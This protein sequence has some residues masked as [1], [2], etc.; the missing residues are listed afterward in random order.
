MDLTTSDSLALHG[1]SSPPD[2]AARSA[3]APPGYAGSRSD[4]ERLGA[5]SS[6]R[7][8]KHGWWVYV[9]RIARRIWRHPANRSR[10]L[11]ALGRSLAWQVRKR[12]TD[13]PMEIGIGG[14]LKILCF[15]D[16]SV[17]SSLIYASGWPEIDEMQFVQ[18]YLRPGDGFVDGG[19]NIGIYTL[20]AASKVGPS[21]WIDA[22]EPSPTALQRLRQNISHNGLSQVRTHAAALGDVAGTARLLV[23]WDVS[24]RL[25]GSEDNQREDEQAVPVP[26]VRLDEI[27]D[28][29]RSYAMAKLDLEGAELRC[30]RGAEE[31]LRL[32]N[33][34]VWQIELTPHLLQKQGS[35]PAELI[36][37]LE[38]RGYDLAIYDRCAHRLRSLGPGFLDSAG[39]RT[40]NVLAVARSARDAVTHRLED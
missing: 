40:T 22:F 39:G 23:G 17:S 25:A 5:M 38:E 30:L 27:L 32:A 29:G 12:W 9:P 33:P 2:P 16:S 15:P 26:T 31:R 7:R 19:A 6:T 8:R 4:P 18:A 10:R 14:G 28:S 1:F 3:H 37:F 20:L 11:E 13:R 34:P 21:G 24:D 35:T 36:G